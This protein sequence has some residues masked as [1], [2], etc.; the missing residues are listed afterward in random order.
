[1]L[2]VDDA[3]WW[4][5]YDLHDLLLMFPGLD[6]VRFRARKNVSQTADMSIASSV[7][8]TGANRD[9]FTHRTD[10]HLDHL[11]TTYLPL[12]DVVQDPFI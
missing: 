1:M 4:E 2:D 6:Q 8:D 10:H 7:D 5:P 3:A 12:S 9:L 11:W